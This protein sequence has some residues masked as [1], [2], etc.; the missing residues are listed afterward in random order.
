MNIGR[1]RAKHILIRQH[2]KV[3][4]ER[5]LDRL[6]NGQARPG[7]VTYRWLKLKQVR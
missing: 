3:Y 7:D 5:A 4:Y 2:R 1:K 6:I